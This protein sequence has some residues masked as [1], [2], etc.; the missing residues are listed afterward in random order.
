MKRHAWTIVRTLLY[1]AGA[2]LVANH[3][4]T[5]NG[6]SSRAAASASS[7]SEASEVSL[8]PKSSSDSETAALRR[9]ILSLNQKLGELRRQIADSR[10]QASAIATQQP[11]E[12][13][14]ARTPEA[15]A[16]QERRWHEH[17]VTIEA[18][19]QREERN[20]GWASST[21]D[22]IRAAFGA[23]DGLKGAIRGVECHSQTC[24]V[25]VL[26]DRSGS[27]GNSLPPVIS[28]LGTVFPSTQADHADLG[29]GTMLLTIYMTRGAFP[30]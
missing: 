5:R 15:V 10:A 13:R 24:K 11:S 18:G 23:N 8:D 12:N 16:E 29:D 9:D 27:V 22:T 3:F 28:Q 21:S 1:G 19:F 4:V 17:M 7:S 2:Y 25:E 14:P 6:N 20:A 26:D 30:D